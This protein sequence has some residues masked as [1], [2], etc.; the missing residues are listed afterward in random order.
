[1]CGRICQQLMKVIG[2]EESSV[3]HNSL[4]KYIFFKNKVLNER[5]LII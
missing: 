4:Q 1:M 3:L 2:I 5:F